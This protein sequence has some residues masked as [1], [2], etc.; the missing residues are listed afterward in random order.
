M[1]LG[2]L[3]GAGTERSMWIDDQEERDLALFKRHYL[4]AS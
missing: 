4:V 2:A 3:P 1:V